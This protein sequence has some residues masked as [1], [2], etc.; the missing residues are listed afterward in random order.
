MGGGAKQVNSGQASAADKATTAATDQSTALSKQYGAQEAQQY[1]NLFGANGKGGTLSGMMDPASLT[2]T[3]LNPAY[4]AQFNQGSDQLGQNYANMRGSLA[5]QFANSGATSS[6][7]PSGFQADQMRKLDS[8]TADSR[9]QLFS[10]LMGQQHSDA[11]TNF[12]NANNIASGQAASSGQGALSG[13]NSA[14]ANQAALFGT[15]GKQAQTGT[16]AATGITEAA[17]CPADGGLILMAD[18]TVRKIE[19]V[20]IGDLILGIDLLPDEVIDIQPTLQNCC[21]IITPSRQTIVSDSHT[22]ERHHGGYTFA[23]K[24]E[25]EEIAFVGGPERVINVIPLAEKKMCR[26]IMLKRSHGYCCDGF[27]SLE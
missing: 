1:G 21:T 6:S 23:R 2:Q 22:F 9:G 8:S 3:G 14:G 12:W 15:A 20:Y 25:G 13:A 11:L 24:S 4:K 16:S 26:H 7:T 27:W 18:N 17:V 10:G 5:Q 19:D